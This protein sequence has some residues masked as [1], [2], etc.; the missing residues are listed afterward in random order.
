MYQS[1]PAIFDDTIKRVLEEYTQNN[2]LGRTT[3]PHVRSAGS[4]YVPKNP[5]RKNACLP[6]AKRV[7]TAPSPQ[8]H[9]SQPPW[10]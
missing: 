2:G 9:F 3:R 7:C 4:D 1:I 8:N 10:S 5:G 6:G